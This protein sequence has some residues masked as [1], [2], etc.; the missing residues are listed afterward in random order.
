MKIELEVP[1]DLAWVVKDI[2]EKT[3]TSFNDLLI[4]LLSLY[5]KFGAV[6][7]DMFKRLGSL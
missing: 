7:L 5:T 2:E 3:G 6:G 4:K 1:D